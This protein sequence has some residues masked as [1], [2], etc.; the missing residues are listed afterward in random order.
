MDEGVLFGADGLA[1]AFPL[2]WQVPGAPD[3]QR[4]ESAPQYFYSPYL[5]PGVPQPLSEW[6]SSEQLASL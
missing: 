4:A 6:F 1:N 3:L 5:A 2:D